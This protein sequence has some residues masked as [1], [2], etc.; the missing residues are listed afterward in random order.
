R[1]PQARHQRACGKR[2]LL[3]A[4]S[5]IP[6]ANLCPQGA[7]GSNPVGGTLS[8]PEAVSRPPS[9]IEP[10]TTSPE[11]PRAAIA[12]PRGIICRPPRANRVALPCP[13]LPA[14]RRGTRRA[15]PSSTARRQRGCGAA[16]AAGAGGGGA[17]WSNIAVGRPHRAS[18]FLALHAIRE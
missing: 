10:P 8:Q 12:A 2:D 15:R 9:D 4:S 6:P 16:A 17:Y 5:G 13:R 14:R 11:R 18:P 3:T 1:L 7:C